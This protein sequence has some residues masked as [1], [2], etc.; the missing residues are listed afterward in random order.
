MLTYDFCNFVAFGVKYA[1]SCYKNNIAPFS[2]FG[3]T[4]SESRRNYSTG[5][6]TLYSTADFFAGSYTYAT[7]IAVS[8]NN[9][10]NNFGCNKGLAATVN[11]PKIR[12]AL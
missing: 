9:I 10:G 1:S 5:T 12:V 4:I 2:N 3:Q 11:A 8:R 6:V 7:S